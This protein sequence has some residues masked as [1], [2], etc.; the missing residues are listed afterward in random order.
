M[1]TKEEDKQSQ[2]GADIAFECLRRAEGAVRANCTARPDLYLR[3]IADPQTSGV[4][5][6]H[7]IGN[8]RN[9][10]R[11]FMKTKGRGVKKSRSRS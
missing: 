6:T 10:A 1:K 3:D 2:A 11:M 8:W 5:A 7:R 9:K 4:C